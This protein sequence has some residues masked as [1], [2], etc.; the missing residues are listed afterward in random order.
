MESYKLIFAFILNIQLVINAVPLSNAKKACPSHELVLGSRAPHDRLLL[1]K[2]I[3]VPAKPFRTLK[4]IETI[5]TPSRETITRVELIDQKIDG[6]GASVQ[7]NK[8][9]GNGPAYRD[10]S[11][12]FNSK[13]NHGVHYSVRLYGH[14]PVAFLLSK[15]HNTAI[16]A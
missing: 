15:P 13:F 14:K 16:K 11:V 6:R 2:F 8:V 3:Y 7:L 10:V 5:R 9:S 12:K 4:H 1:Q